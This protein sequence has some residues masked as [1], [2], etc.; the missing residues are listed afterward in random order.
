MSDPTA[1]DRRIAE[2]GALFG[3][4]PPNVEALFAPS[5]LRQVSAGQLRALV[6]QLTAKLGPLSTRA[7]EEELGAGAARYRFTFTRGFAVAVTLRLGGAAPHLVEGLLF[8]PPVRLAADLDEI[9]R[10]L[11]ELPGEVSFLLARVDAAAA[12]QPPRVTT[13]AAVEPERTLAIASAFKLYV[14][15]ELV[16]AVENRERQWDD[17]AHLD[18]ADRSLPSGKLQTWPVGSPLTL[19]TAATLMISESDN[20]ATD[21]LLRVLGDERLE[22]MQRRAGHATPERNIP[23]LATRE[24]FALTSAAGTALA[25]RWAGT[26]DAQARRAIAAEAAAL[27]YESL[28]P[29]AVRGRPG[30]IG[31]LEWFASARDLV[32]VMAWLR[33]HTQEA[34]TAPGRAVLA[35]NP[36]IGVPKARWP[37]VGFKGGSEEGVLNV[38]FLLRGA[39]DTWYALAA[40]WNDPAGAVD[41]NDLLP[42]VQRAVELAE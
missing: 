3:D 35:I 17:V 10:E 6:E 4:A 30:D 9:V 21:L 1:L 24:M 12:G 33:D 36:G 28:H 7:L 27:P 11:R 34:R 5:F 23:F 14:L 38:T 37:Y 25:A 22:S 26:G 13:L 29:P 8:G 20:T 2:I 31:R 40:T 42:L 16:R 18:A 19:H 15:A 41:P 39:D 32:H